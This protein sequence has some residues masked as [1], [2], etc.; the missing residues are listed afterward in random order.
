[1]FEGPSGDAEREKLYAALRHYSAGQLSQALDAWKELQREPQNMIELLMVAEC[2][3]DKGEDSAIEHLKK[4]R[5]LGMPEAE[6]VE[7][8]LRQMKKSKNNAEFFQQ[9]AQG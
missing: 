9:M 6:A 1:M 3:A 2:E 4:M 7:F 5:Q 8:L